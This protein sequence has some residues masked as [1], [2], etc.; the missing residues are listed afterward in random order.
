MA[1]ITREPM[2]AWTCDPGPLRCPHCRGALRRTEAGFDCNAEACGAPLPVRDGVLVVR[3]A[4]TD[5]N[6]IAADFYN[7]KLW[8][9]V[10]FWERLFWLVNGGERRAR[11]VVPLTPPPEAAKWR[12]ALRAATVDAKAYAKALS[13][14]LRSICGDGDE[15][16]A[17]SVVRGAGFQ[18]RLK[19]SGRAALDLIDDLTNRNNKD[20]PV[21]ASLTDDDRSNLLQ[22]KIE[23]RN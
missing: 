8:P 4:P 16:I 10:R 5:D 19:A 13:E 15:T 14:F 17:R 18:S 9:K 2:G 23:A 11:D 12:K 7:G 6:K 21:S 20:C 1:T 22:I 3:D